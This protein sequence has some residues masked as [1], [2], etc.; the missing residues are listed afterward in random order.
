MSL[1]SN[2]SVNGS[3]LNLAAQNFVPS[4]AATNLFVDG[5]PTINITAVPLLT[6]FPTQLRLIQY[7]Y[8]GGTASGN[9]GAIVLG[10][11]PGGATPPYGGY[12][13]NN[14][15][16][17]SI[18]LVLTNGPFVPALVWDNTFRQLGYL[19]HGQL[20]AQR[21]ARTPSSLTMT[22]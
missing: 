15:A 7:G 10:T 11:L 20:A 19:D 3:S 16:N 5:S 1:L 9:L 21:L 13:S 17:N 2:F 8:G 18:D 12:I 6:G 14:T 22:S 4:I